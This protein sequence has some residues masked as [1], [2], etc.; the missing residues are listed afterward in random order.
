MKQVKLA[1]DEVIQQAMKDLSMDI[2]VVV[3]DRMLKMIDD[4]VI[5]TINTVA[6]MQERIKILE[7]ENEQLRGEGQ[8][9]EHKNIRGKEYYK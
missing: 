7:A 4:G 5:L 8:I 1:S 6:D 3:R 9:P 2:I